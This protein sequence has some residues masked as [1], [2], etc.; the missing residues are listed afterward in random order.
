[1][2]TPKLTEVNVSAR[3]GGMEDCRHALIS[4]AETYVHDYFSYDGSCNSWDAPNDAAE[5][6]ENAIRECAADIATMIC[7][8][9]GHDWQR[10]NDITRCCRRCEC[11]ERGEHLR[12][13][14]A[15]VA[16]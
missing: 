1:M 4:K 12:A 15:E 10:W 3:Q 2:S 7:A 14:L 13:V 8:E 6:H 5:E 9:F 11:Q 16:P